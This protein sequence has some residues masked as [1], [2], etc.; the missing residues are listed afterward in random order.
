MGDSNSSE[1]HI[2]KEQV[3]EF[4]CSDCT[5]DG[6]KK[7]L[8]DSLTGKFGRFHTVLQFYFDAFGSG[9][10]LCANCQEV[11]SYS[12]CIPC[13]LTHVEKWLESVD[14]PLAIRLNK[15]MLT[16]DKLERLDDLQELNS[17]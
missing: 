16:G 14:K 4:V 7:W 12:L 3:W 5:A 2:C 9:P 8:P 15:F 17:I 11:V 13:Y 10:N 6:I 1:C